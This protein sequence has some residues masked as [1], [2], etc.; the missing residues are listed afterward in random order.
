M[1]TVENLQIL[2]TCVCQNKYNRTNTNHNWHGIIDVLITNSPQK[3]KSSAVIRL[4]ISDHFMIYVCIKDA[5]NRPPRKIVESR[6]FKNYSKFSFKRD[7]FDTLNST[8][9]KKEL[10]QRRIQSKSK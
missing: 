6:S 1:T 4:G 7:V 5:I 8:N 10:D 3:F 2:W 9:I